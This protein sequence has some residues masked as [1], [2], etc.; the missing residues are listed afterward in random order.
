M[1]ASQP[2]SQVAERSSSAPHR[3]ISPSHK[4]AAI[5]NAVLAVFTVVWSIP[6]LQGGQ[7]DSDQVPWPVVVLGFAIGALC[8]V[9]SYGV[10][11]GQRWGVVL[12]IVLNAISFI[13]GAPGIPFG[14]N[15]FVIIGSIIG[16]IGAV[17]I[18][19]L[20]MRRGGARRSAGTAS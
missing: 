1:S 12:T 11:R 3:Q 9:S 2:L 8:L 14:P 5:L 15:A 17:V 19:Y 7:D 10:W 16:C 6:A 13:T 20:L 18:I 4:A